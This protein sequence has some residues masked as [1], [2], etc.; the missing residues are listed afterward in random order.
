MSNKLQA[1]KINYRNKR[2]NQPKW[3]EREQLKIRLY[4]FTNQANVSRLFKTSNQNIN[5]A[6]RGLNALLMNKIKSY[7]EKMEA[8]NGGDGK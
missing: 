1:E 4:R 8:R 7:I 3:D 5:N 2:H 6:F